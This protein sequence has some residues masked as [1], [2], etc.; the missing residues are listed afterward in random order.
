MLKTI[1]GKLLSVSQFF[2]W[3]KKE[4]GYKV[5]IKE[6]ILDYFELSNSEKKIILTRRNLRKFPSLTNVVEIINSIQGSREV[7]L[8]D[9]ALISLL[10]LTG[11]R[12]GTLINLQ[13]KDFDAVQ[14]K[15]LESG[16]TIQLAIDGEE[17]SIIL[18]DVI[19]ISS[20]IKG[21][22][23]ETD[24]NVT[25]AIDT[26]LDQKLI[27]EGIAREFVNRIQNMR[28]G[29][30]FEVTDKISIR[31]TSS[32][33]INSAVES[34]TKYVAAETLAENVVNVDKLNGGIKQDWEIGDHSCSIQ[35]EKVK[36]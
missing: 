23:V 15:K 8:R 35:I 2:I 19:I 31:F 14:I 20:E 25:V 4:D 36:S 6:S 18:E 28:K 9:R 17:H 26:E 33:I 7:D 13:I 11:I 24:G 21:W 12:D 5:K 34:F 22:V 32:D 1:S 16:N 30:G 29:A 3:L 10:M 27:E